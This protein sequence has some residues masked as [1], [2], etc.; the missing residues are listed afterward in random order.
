MLLFSSRGSTI[1]FF[2]ETLQCERKKEQNFTQEA[3]TLA[4][5]SFQHAEELKEKTIERK[6]HALQ[7]H[8]PLSLITLHLLL[9]CV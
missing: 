1:R 7:E 3:L 9:W 5:K 6:V 2:R 4:E 8:H